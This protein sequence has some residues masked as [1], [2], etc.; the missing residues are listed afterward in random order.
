MNLSS[1]RMALANIT[2]L[3]ADDDLACEDILIGLPV[4]ENMGI[5][6]CTLLE[7]NRA[8]IDGTDCAEVG[9]PSFSASSGVLDRLILSID[10][11]A[12][13]DQHNDPTERFDRNDTVTEPLD[14][15]RP[16]HNYFANQRIDDPFPN[17]DLIEV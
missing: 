7:R 15:D 11:F 1:E 4:L 9:N 3:V 2:F 14:L 6:S 12:Y 8:V 5:D 13:G 16:R 17:P 10:E